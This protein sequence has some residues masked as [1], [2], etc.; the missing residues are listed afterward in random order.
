[1]MAEQRRAAPTLFWQSGFIGQ[2]TLR[3]L[4][5]HRTLLVTALLVSGMAIGISESWTAVD[6]V[7]TT[8]WTSAPVHVLIYTLAL[9]IVASGALRAPATK[10]TAEEQEEAL[11]SLSHGLRTP[12]NAVIG[13][14]EL[15]LAEVHGPL[16]HA[17]YVDYARHVSESGMRLASFTEQI[18]R[19]REQPGLLDHLDD[20]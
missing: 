13:F 9:A 16:G 8:G 15:M 10:P 7:H 20:R 17:K 18:L 4:A 5:H 2:G 12:L 14:S 3:R 6:T 11:A 1:M 19:S